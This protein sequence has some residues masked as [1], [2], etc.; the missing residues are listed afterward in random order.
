[1]G[2]SAAAIIDRPVGATQ[3]R[4]YIKRNLDGV[5]AAIYRIYKFGDKVRL[6]GDYWRWSEE[7]W[8]EEE[9]I[10]RCY[11]NGFD[12][13]VDDATEDEVIGLIQARRS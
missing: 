11:W 7:K 10:I 3:L 13:D 12:A 5:H 6:H 2:L 1:M 8:I 4:Y 9:D